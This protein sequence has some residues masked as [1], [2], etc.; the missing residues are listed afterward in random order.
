MQRPTKKAVYEIIRTEFNAIHVKAYGKWAIVSARA[1]PYPGPIINIIQFMKRFSISDETEFT[2][3][4]HRK[5]MQY[6]KK[7][8]NVTS[9]Q[10][11]PI[12]TKLID[13]FPVEEIKS[14]SIAPATSTT[15]TSPNVNTNTKQSKSLIDHASLAIQRLLWG[16]YWTKRAK[17][18]LYSIDELTGKRKLRDHESYI[19]G[20]GSLLFLANYSLSSPTSIQCFF[21]KCIL[22]TVVDNL[23]FHKLFIKGLQPIY[24]FNQVSQKR[25][26]TI[27][28]FAI[29]LSSQ[30]A[31][32]AYFK[33]GGFY[34]IT[35][36]SISAAEK[37]CSTSMQWLMDRP[38]LTNIQQSYP[39]TCDLIE[40]LVSD[41]G[42]FAGVYLGLQLHQ[43]ANIPRSHYRNSYEK[44]DKQQEQK[45]NQKQQ[46]NQHHSQ[47]NKQYHSKKDSHRNF[48]GLSNEEVSMLQTER[49][50]ILRKEI[51][52]RVSST[53]LGVPYGSNKKQIKSAYRSLSLLYHPDKCKEP[54]CSDD[55][56]LI[57]L[58]NEILS[59][60]CM[61]L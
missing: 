47:Q 4:Q 20:L 58:A 45:R 21:T 56:G 5:F 11:K 34:T 44:Q 29:M 17:S 23:Q 12:I 54:R 53:V 13:T 7:A 35:F 49:S 50:C 43:W 8:M 42:A 51:C 2:D 3:D 28:S 55:M 52:C 9:D 59:T 14:E 19:L 26:E 46:K 48:A 1:V 60:R 27:S 36:F 16:A 39:H 41:I 32:D 24:K 10:Y 57:N 40:S 31:I 61:T 25:A 15:S 38:F 22:Q 30:I 18:I 33:T 6:I 37:L